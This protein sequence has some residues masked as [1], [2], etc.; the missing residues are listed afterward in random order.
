VRDDRNNP[1]GESAWLGGPLLARV[2]LAGL[3]A[4]ALVGLGDIATAIAQNRPDAWIAVATAVVVLVAALISSVAGCAFAALAGGAL[5]YLDSDPVSV[6]RTIVVC[7]LAIQL[8]GVWKLRASI[9]W[10]RVLV[11]LLGAVFTLPLGVWL[12]VRLD[13]ASYAGGLGVFLVV[14]GLHLLLHREMR[15]RHGGA[16]TGT[17]AGAL[18]GLAGGLAGLPG[19]PVTIW[20]SM[21]G[22]DKQQ[23]RAVYQPFILVMQLLTMACL[24]WQVP[25]DAHA[26]QAIAFVPFAVF[27]AIGGLAVYQRL[28]NRQFRVTTSAMLVVSGAGLLARTL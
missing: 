18:G 2:A 10:Q 1:S 17:F 7:S 28:T 6:V 23:Q 14:Y 27:G 26:A 4:W 5:A 22:W 15:M 13:A 3:S 9:R 20:C 19:A 24:H 8:Y 25:L 16:W 12:L 11:P 21:R